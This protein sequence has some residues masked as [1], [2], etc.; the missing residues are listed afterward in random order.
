MCVFLNPVGRASSVIRHNCP[1]P[2][3][4]RQLSVLWCHLF[5]AVMVGPSFCVLGIKVYTLHVFGAVLHCVAPFSSVG[6]F[7]ANR[8]QNTATLLFLF[9]SWTLRTN[10]GSHREKKGLASWSWLLWA[11]AAFCKKKGM[12]SFSTKKDYEMMREGGAVKMVE[13][14]KR[15][16]VECNS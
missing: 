15:T 8:D 3:S 9:P 16:H 1:T 6:P 7:G 5:N 11:C 4:E 14:M 12:L 10:N 2:I 13:L